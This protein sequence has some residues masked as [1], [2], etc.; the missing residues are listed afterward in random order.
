MTIS[1]IPAVGFW[2][3]TSVTRYHLKVIIICSSFLFM[4]ILSERNLFPREKELISVWDT[5]AAA[6]RTI[7]K[8][9]L[10]HSQSHDQT[11]TFL[12]PTCHIITSSWFWGIRKKEKWVC[13][14]MCFIIMG[15]VSLP[16]VKDV[17]RPPFS[18]L[19]YEL[20]TLKQPWCE[21]LEMSSLA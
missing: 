12:F 15:D 1:E 19:V 3:D 13:S 18:P 9:L 5:S 2:Q 4:C 21:H 7:L 10:L 11:G 20:L 14:Q 6:C 16:M 8:S 17:S